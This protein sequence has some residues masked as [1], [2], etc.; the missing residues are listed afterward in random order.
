MNLTSSLS[1]GRVVVPAAL[2]SQLDIKDGDQLI[3]TAVDGSLVATTR[4]AQ[5][6]KAQA[7]FQKLIPKNSPSLADELIAERRKAAAT[8]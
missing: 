7:L 3:W 8:E 5:L 4:R 6:G 1:N 2:R